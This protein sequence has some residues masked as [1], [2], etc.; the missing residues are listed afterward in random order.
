MELS[1]ILATSAMPCWVNKSIKNGPT[2]IK[3][4]LS[5]QH[6]NLDR[7]WRQLGLILGGFGGQNGAKSRS[8]NRSKNWSHFRS[9]LGS[10]L[11][12][13]GPQLGAQNGPGPALLEPRCAQEPQ[14]CGLRQLL[15]AQ[16]NPGLFEIDFSSILHRFS[17]P[18]GPHFHWFLIDFLIDFYGF[19]SS[20]WLTFHRL[21]KDSGTHLASF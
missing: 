17:T 18:N 7:F 15:D 11:A 2:Y 19:W 6:P 14:N 21:W 16:T 13:F 4:H 1:T 20:L 8:P 10:I 3:K 12:D 5:N 9:L